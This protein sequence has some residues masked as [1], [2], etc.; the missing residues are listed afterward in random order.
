MGTYDPVPLQYERMS[1]EEQTRRARLFLELCA[2][3]RSVRS[4]S[5][6]PISRSLIE[7]IVKTATTAPSGANKQPWRFVVV[8]SPELKHRIRVAAEA[9]L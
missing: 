6:Q 7:T 1:E 9:K 5:S 4:F 3:R 8:D 2:R